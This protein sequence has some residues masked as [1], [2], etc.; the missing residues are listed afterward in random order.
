MYIDI[1]G[2]HEEGRSFGVLKKGKY[3][4]ASDF[5]FNFVAEVIC[6]DPHSSGFIVELEPDRPLYAA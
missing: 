4:A 5:S 2:Y 1:I 6:D 3:K